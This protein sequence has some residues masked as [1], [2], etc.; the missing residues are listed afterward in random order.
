MGCNNDYCEIERKKDE[1]KLEDYPTIRNLDGCY[2]R[3]ER[4]GKWLNLCFSDLTEQERGK[5]MSGKGVPWLISLAEHLADTLHAFG[6]AFGIYG[7]DE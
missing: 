4:D 6:D 5:V 3:V 2:F 1:E 7:R